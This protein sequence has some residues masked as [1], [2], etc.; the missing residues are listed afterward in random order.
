MNF[1]DLTAL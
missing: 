1:D